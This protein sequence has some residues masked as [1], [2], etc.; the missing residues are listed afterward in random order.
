M[1]ALAARRSFLEPERFIAGPSLLAPTGG[2]LARVDLDAAPASLEDRGMDRLR[3]RLPG[4]DAHPALGRHRVL[5]AAAALGDLLCDAIGARA[6]TS[7]VVDATDGRPRL[8]LATSRASFGSVLLDAVSRVLLAAAEFDMTVMEDALARLI[9]AWDRPGCAGLLASAALRRG[10]PVS[11]PAGDDGDLVLGEGARSRVWHEGGRGS[12]A[13]LRGALASKLA[14]AR[15]LESAGLPTGRPVAVDTADDAVSEAA[16]RGYPV[17]LKPDQASL[18]VGVFTHLHSAAAVRRAFRRALA[19][20]GPLAGPL[21]IERQGRGTYLRATL[22]GGRLEAAVA[23]RAPEAR[24]DGVRNADALA[25]EALDV[26]AAEEPD[27]RLRG[28]LES[29][30]RPQGLAPRSVPRRGQRFRVAHENH[31]DLADVTGA[32]HPA[33]RRLLVRVARVIAL[34][35]IGVDMLVDDPRGPLDPRD[36]ILEVNARPDLRLHDLAASP[37]SPG[38]AGAV[39]DHLFPGGGRAARVPVVAGSEGAR[40]ALEALARD[41]RSAGAG[42]GGYTRGRAW[43]ATPRGELGSGPAAARILRTHPSVEVI[44]LEVDGRLAGEHGLPFEH[45]D[46]LCESGRSPSPVDALLAALHRR[47]VPRRRRPRSRSILAEIEAPRAPG[48]S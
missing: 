10:V 19:W 31:G 6:G 13:S 23:S 5:G 30:L 14:V 22:V 8:L 16:R 3:A 45:V 35:V 46:F 37:R 18:Q 40:K 25:R 9:G 36:Q 38:L 33:I 4:L 47:G 15:R 17:V 42:V 7:A 41:L 2:L 32:L 12:A 21:L 24:G 28:I 44:V 48:R 43:L 20:A 29:V 27:A 1:P 34:P 26:P 11:W 39:V